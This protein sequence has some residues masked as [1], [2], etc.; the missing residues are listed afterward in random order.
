MPLSGVFTLGSGKLWIG[1]LIFEY[2]SRDQTT[3]LA[4]RIIRIP[5]DPEAFKANLDVPLEGECRFFL[6]GKQASELTGLRL[7]VRTVSL[8]TEPRLNLTLYS[9]RNRIRDA[10]INLTSDTE[11][12]TFYYPGSTCSESQSWLSIKCEPDM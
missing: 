12:V 1:R 10:A 5:A 7:D 11:G 8:E 2:G 9:G 3:S 6:D 4:S